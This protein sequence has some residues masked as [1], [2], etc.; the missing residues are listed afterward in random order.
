MHIYF[1]G[2]LFIGINII[3]AV[4]F[5]SIDRPRQAFLIS[6]L[7]GFLLVIPLAFLLSSLLGLTGIWL[8]VPAAEGLVMLL[9]AV[10]L[11]RSKNFAEGR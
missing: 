6:C 2:F 8:T 1:T 7:R 3:S 11:F 9:A 5:S 10:M 4:Y